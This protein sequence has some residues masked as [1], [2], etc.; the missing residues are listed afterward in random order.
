MIRSIPGFK[1]SGRVA[2]RSVIAGLAG[3]ALSGF[4]SLEGWLAP[5]SRLWSRWEPHDPTGTRRIDWAPFDRWL[6][7]HVHATTEGVNRVDYGRVGEA[8]RA[9]LA[10]IVDTLAAIPVSDLNRDE[11]FAYW[12]N[13][14]NAVTLKVVLDHYPVDS[15]H[16]INL[17]GDL[18]SEGPW[19]AN[20]VEVEGEPLS[21]DEIEHR[22]LRPIWQDSRI[23]YAVNCAAVGCPNLRNAAWRPET[24]QQ[25]L[26][27]AARAYINHP[28]G[29]D[30]RPIDGIPHLIV[31]K[32]YDWY[33]EDFGGSEATVLAH[34][35]RYAE[36]ATA[37]ALARLNHIHGT[38]YDW[39]LN[40]LKALR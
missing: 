19:K 36:G 30:V 38:D 29:V 16:A 28:R 33:A 24:L 6:S 32:I 22:I 18:V 37:D 34:L 20:L 15:I 35:R 11:Q 10:G 21:L 7:E 5:S 3:L 27:A 40:D 13:L 23:H 14:Y 17:G 8:E 31:S 2:R 26:D 1:A 39:T 12:I 25:E 9:E 4:R